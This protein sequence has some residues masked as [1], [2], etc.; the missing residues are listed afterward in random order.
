MKSEKNG[1]I[2]LPRRQILTLRG[3]IAAVDRDGMPQFV[4]AD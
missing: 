1:F 2:A 3:F 4:E